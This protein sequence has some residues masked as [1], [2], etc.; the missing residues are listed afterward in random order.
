MNL[1]KSKYCKGITCDK[2]LWLS[3]YKPDVG[4]DLNDDNVFRMGKEVGEVAKGLF[5]KYYDIEFNEDLSQMINETEKA[6]DEGY[7]VITE[8]SFVYDNNFCSVDILRCNDKNV[9]I[10]EVKSA[11]EINDIYLDDISYQTYILLGLGYKVSKACIVYI[12]NGYVRNGDLE[13][14]KLFNMEDVTGIVFDKQSEVKLKIDKLDECIKRKDEPDARLG[15][16]CVKPYDCP[17]FEYCCKYLPVNNVFKIRGMTNS[18]K[19]KFYDKGIYSYEDLLNEDIKDKYKQQIEFTLYGKNTYIDVN[20]IKDFMKDLYYPLYFLDFETYQQPIPKYDGIR[21]YM[22]VPFQY[23][24]HYLESVDSELKHKEFLAKADIDPRRSL[25]ESLVRDIPIDSCVLAY[26]MKFEKMVIRNLA[27]VYPD[28]SK[29]LM[30]IYNNM[31]DLMIPFKNRDY[32]ISGM[33]GSF[34]IKYVLPAMFPDDPSLDYHNLELIHNGTE[35]MSSFADLGT[36]TKEEQE[37]IRYNLLKYCELDTYAMV[38]I[39]NK[40]KEIC[41]KNTDL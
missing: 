40:L 7:K 24:L 29:H 8:A 14:D 23:S 30:N 26:N 17:F 16:H 32:Y 9:E 1:S 2:M 39:Y 28:L 38:K 13:L 36:K 33:E 20:K 12:N 21:P 5:G 35:A 18:S 25:A 41:E 3:I 6:I 31:Y 10:Y 11:T 15:M 22:Q 4:K 37:I 34:S 19:F 27:D